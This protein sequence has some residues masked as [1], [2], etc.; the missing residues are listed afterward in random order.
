MAPPSNTCRS[1]V[2]ARR[3]RDDA[4]SGPPARPTSGDSSALL[5]AS[6]PQDRMLAFLRLALS[7][8]RSGVLAGSDQQS[9]VADR[10]G[11]E[12]RVSRAGE[13]ARNAR[14]RDDPLG[15]TASSRIIEYD[16][17]G[18]VDWRFPDI[19]PIPASYVTHRSAPVLVTAA[20]GH[21][22]GRGPRL[23]WRWGFHRGSHGGPL[24]DEILV[25][26]VYRGPNRV[27]DIKGGVRSQDL[28]SYLGI[29]DRTT[30]SLGMRPETGRRG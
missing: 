12:N 7:R 10:N 3:T 5:T 8:H 13:R 9:Y 14:G 20:A 28:L 1:R 23:G 17:P 18:R 2:S 21:D 11:I 29:L 24:Q 16:D 25:S 30:T 4:Q 15:L 22:F 26:A 19:V 27:P 6:M